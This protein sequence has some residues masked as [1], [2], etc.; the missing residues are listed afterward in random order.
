MTVEEALALLDTLLQQEPLND[1]QEQIFR[2]CWQGETYA[3]MAESM[4]Y[5]AG[6]IKDT[7]AKLWKLLSD[8]LAERV[9]KSNVQSVLKRQVRSVAAAPGAVA[10]G[11][12]VSGNVGDESAHEAAIA[13][14]S[15]VG[16]VPPP[17]S[18]SLPWVDW[19]EAI[20]VSTF[21]GRTVE[22]ATLKQ[23]ILEEGCRSIS[24]LGMGG[25]GKTALSVKL[26]EEIS[27]ESESAHPR[28]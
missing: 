2:Y 6:Y 11:A 4:G 14:E 23:W 18:K 7:G 15:P 10:L 1:I 12:V 21:Y 16:A 27:H 3:D 5:D 13:L 26:A 25:I 24:L 17:S 8:A 20:D 19:G 28:P 9:T 22:L